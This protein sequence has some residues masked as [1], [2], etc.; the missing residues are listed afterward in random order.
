MRVNKS[1]SIFSHMLTMH[2][3]SLLSPHKPT[4]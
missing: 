3:D 2:K 4:Y 1:T